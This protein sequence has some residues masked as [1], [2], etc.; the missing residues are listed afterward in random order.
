MKQVRFVISSDTFGRNYLAISVWNCTLDD[1]V[2]VFWTSFKN[3]EILQKEIAKHSDFGRITAFK[4][5]E[6]A[7]SVCREF[8]IKDYTIREILMDV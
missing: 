1:P 4:T 3:W 6:E 8:N 7:E 5:R 2:G